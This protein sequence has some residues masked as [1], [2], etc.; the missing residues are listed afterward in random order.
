MSLLVLFLIVI[1]CGVVAALLRAAPDTV[2][3]EPFKTILVWLLVVLA[4]VAI[5]QFF[6]LWSAISSFHFGRG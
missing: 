5:G 3:A 4:V 1:G 2:I 6:G